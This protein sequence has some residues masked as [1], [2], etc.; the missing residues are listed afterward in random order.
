MAKTMCS[1]MLPM[2][3]ATQLISKSHVFSGLFLV[4]TLGGCSLFAERGELPNSFGPRE[5]IFYGDVDQVW[6]ATQ[7]AFSKYPIRI[8]NLDLG[9]LE[10]DV[11]TGYKVWTPPHKPSVSGGMS[12]KLS[13]RVVKGVVENR[14]AVRVTVQKESE[15]KRDFFAETQKLPS[16]GLEEKALLYRIG[17]ELQ[18]DKALKKA[19]E[20]LNNK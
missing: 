9:I 16:D 20:N 10:T 19:Q 2:S 5:Q 18:I 13:V 15:L 8:N 14:S 7:I 1:M 6:R 4:L 12:S 11:S 17:R 3:L